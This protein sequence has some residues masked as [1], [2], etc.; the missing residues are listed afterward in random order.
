MRLVSRT[1]GKYL[2]RPGTVWGF[3][4]FEEI[5]SAFPQNSIQDAKCPRFFQVIKM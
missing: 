1:D 3:R 4:D 2:I 5:W